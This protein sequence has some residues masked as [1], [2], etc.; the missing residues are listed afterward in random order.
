MQDTLKDVWCHFITGYGPGRTTSGALVV[1]FTECF[2]ITGDLSLN[3]VL[4][5]VLLLLVA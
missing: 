4:G 3:F 2:H 1:I 5:R